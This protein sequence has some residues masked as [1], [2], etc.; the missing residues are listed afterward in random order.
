M[1]VIYFLACHIDDKLFNWILLLETPKMH[2]TLSF[3]Q[4]IENLAPLNLT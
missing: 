3:V 1:C 2:I 4:G